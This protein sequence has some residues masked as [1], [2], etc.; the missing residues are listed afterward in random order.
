MI[1]SNMALQAAPIA[2]QKKKILA[3]ESRVRSHIKRCM[4]ARVK[5]VAAIIDHSI[6]KKLIEIFYILGI[7]CQLSFSTI[8]FGDGKDK[9]WLLWDCMPDG[10]RIFLKL[11]F[12]ARGRGH[13]VYKLGVHSC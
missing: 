4:K 8:Y 12:I 10:V 2:A 7:F 9:V 11:K 3:R 1:R 5:Q 6:V 13:I